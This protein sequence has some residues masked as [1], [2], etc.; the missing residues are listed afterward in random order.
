MPNEEER[1]NKKKVIEFIKKLDEDKKDLRD[2][3]MKKNQEFLNFLKD[4]NINCCHY[5]FSQTCLVKYSI[6]KSQGLSYTGPKNCKRSERKEWKFGH[7]KDLKV[8]EPADGNKTKLNT[9]TVVIQPEPLPPASSLLDDLLSF[10]AE[11]SEETDIRPM[12]IPSNTLSA[13][14]RPHF[15][16]DTI[17]DIEAM[18]EDT[19]VEDKECAICGVNELNTINMFEHWEEDHGLGM[20]A[21]VEMWNIALEDYD[22]TND[23]P[24]STSEPSTYLPSQ[25]SSSTTVARDE[26]IHRQ[27]DPSSTSVS[28]A[29]STAFQENMRPFREDIEEKL[30]F[31]RREILGQDENGTLR[32]VDDNVKKSSL[33]QLSLFRQNI[34]N[35]QD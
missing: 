30:N 17:P 35:C 24:E 22:E 27:S 31:L 28:Q 1:A 6:A 8:W 12:Q 32:N 9:A 19:A 2:Q 33:C 26:H 20:E 4:N 5:C 11:N 15:T 25:K 21:S 23:E 14:S 34:P 7:L 29:V 10:E 18:L 13:R 16:A 3:A